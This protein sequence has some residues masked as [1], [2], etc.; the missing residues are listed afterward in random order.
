M[1]R[2]IST[3]EPSEITER[4][5]LKLL[6]DLCGL[7]GRY[8]LE[9]YKQMKYNPLEFRKRSIYSSSNSSGSGSNSCNVFDSLPANFRIMAIAQ[10]IT[11]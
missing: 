4:E 9:V 5:I 6:C 2:T 8:L 7:C 10:A 3:T 11:T 1:R